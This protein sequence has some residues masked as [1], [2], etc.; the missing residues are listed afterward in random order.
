MDDAQTW[1]LRAFGLDLQADFAVPGASRGTDG[2]PRGRPLALRWV[3][4]AEL[5]PLVAEPRILRWLHVFEGRP[6]AMLEAADGDILFVYGGDAMFHL[7]ADRAVLRCAHDGGPG[8]SWQRVLLDTVLWTTSLMAGYELLHAGA[9][10][11]RAGV[12][13]IVA[14][15]GAGKTS[16]VAEC[17][18]RGAALFCDDILALEQTGGGVLAHPGPPVMNLPGAVPAGRLGDAEVLDRFGD[19]QWVRVGRVAAGPAPLHAVVL[20]RRAAGETA[21]CIPLDATLLDLLPH[22]VWLWPA[23]GRERRRFELF[24]QLAAGARVLRLAAD[25]ALSTAGLADLLE[26]RIGLA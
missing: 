7:S 18:A 6:Y 13:A 25:P 16:L 20:L 5:Q 4:A 15:S 26:Q 10:A 14:E 12:V 9:I 11:T 2:V 24:G 19:E 23:P 8:M 21:R 3:L 1:G 22:A 17:V